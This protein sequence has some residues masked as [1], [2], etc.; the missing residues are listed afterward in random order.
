MHKVPESSQFRQPRNPEALKIQTRF[1]IVKKPMDLS[2]IKT[3]LTTG[4]YSE[5]REYINDVWLMI[6]SARSKGSK[7]VA[8]K[9]AYVSKSI[10]NSFNQSFLHLKIHSNRI[11]FQ[12]SEVF[13]EAIDSPMQSLGYCCGRKYMLSPQILFCSTIKKCIIA[14]HAKYYSHSH[15]K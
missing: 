3:K 7:A 10:R 1:D 5:P 12:L 9:C 14:S 4:Q 15:N 2:A 13:N 8:R 11:R 6:N